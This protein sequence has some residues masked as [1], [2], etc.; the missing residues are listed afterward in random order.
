MSFS[1][2]EYAG[3]GKKTR[4]EYFFAAMDQVVP[5]T[6]MLGLIKPF[7]PKV[8]GDRE[9]L[10]LDT[11]LRIY[12]LLNWLSP[13]DP[14]M[15]EALNEITPIRQ[16]ASLT[17]SAPIPDDTR[18]MNFRHLLETHQLAPAILALINGY[19][20]KKPCRCVKKPSSIQSLFMSPAHQGRRRQAQLRDASDEER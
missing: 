18:I 2:F 3:R 17:L 6:G 16:F 15:G 4:R 20:R 7:Y 5:W 9:P 10:P 14:V 13:S 1:D 19:C 8:G 12:L 11:M